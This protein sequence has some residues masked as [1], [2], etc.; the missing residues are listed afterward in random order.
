MSDSSGR[1]EEQDLILSELI[2]GV[3]LSR[4]PSGAGTKKI[5]SSDFQRAVADLG[6]PVGT[7]VVQDMLV[8]CK[9]DS[10]GNIDFAPLERE[11]VARRRILS[12]KPKPQAAPPPT[13][14]AANTE[15]IWRIEREHEKRVK[16]EQQAKLVKE[17]RPDLLT[18]FK[19]FSHGTDRSF[20]TEQVISELEKL[21]I[22]CTRAMRVLLDERKS[23]SDVSFVKFCAVMTQ[24]DPDEK[25][26]YDLDVGAGKPSVAS[27]GATMDERRCIRRGNFAAHARITSRSNHRKEGQ[28]AVLPNKASIVNDQLS[29]G[30]A[31]LYKD[32]S[33]MAAT[34]KPMQTGH[35][36]AM[37]TH[38]QEQMF[39][40]VKGNAPV[41]SYNSELRLQR[42]QILAALRKLDSHEISLDEFHSKTRAIGFEVPS[43]ILKL[44]HESTIVGRL[45]WR[46]CISVLDT[47]V[48][49]VKALDEVPSA[50]D[51]DAIKASI[52]AQLAEKGDGAS[53]L[54]LL[55]TAFSRMD[56][57]KNQVLS[58]NEFSAGVSAAGLDISDDDLRC[59]FHALDVN[60]DGALNISEF[61]ALLRP[62]LPNARK[63]YIRNAFS[64]LDRY[65]AQS[66]AIHDLVDGFHPEGHVDVKSGVKTARQV[67]TEMINAFRLSSPS[68]DSYDGLVSYEQFSNYLASLSAFIES[69]RDF[70]DMM[71]ACWGVT[72]RAPAPPVGCYAGKDLDTEGLSRP[73]AKQQ[74]GD[75]ISWNQEESEYEVSTR[76]KKRDLELLRSMHQKDSDVILWSKAGGGN[77]GAEG[78]FEGF[79]NRQ[80]SSSSRVGSA[81]T[82]KH[83]VKTSSVSSSSA[84]ALLPP[85]P[86]SSSPQ[87]SQAAAGFKTADRDKLRDSNN[88]RHTT[89]YSAAARRNFGGPTP[90]GVS[91]EVR[92]WSYPHVSRPSSRLSPSPPLLSLA[93]THT[94]PTHPQPPSAMY[95][96]EN[97]GARPGATSRGLGGG[98]VSAQ[99][100][101]AVSLRERA[102]APKSLADYVKQ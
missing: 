64:K 75:I 91:F 56:A 71:T 63:V 95:V 101:L 67:V 4:D 72:D 68:A 74:H 99:K 40:G 13:S 9:L 38:N 14:S 11:L 24:Y 21:G 81:M 18:I 2:L 27:D 83:G 3:L 77:Q 43:Y 33:S 55:Q 54:V 39:S 53:A 8:H 50:E 70:I 52:L 96:T 28:S 16:M 86:P 89:K 93:H 36:Q 61:V 84:S 37:L 58:F 73:A 6:F 94:P 90:F 46:K 42:E 45:D 88:V 87:D 80:S 34:L 102:N 30:D 47:T 35:S 1:D 7:P 32:S 15:S 25:P 85:P 41:I 69:D 29:Y 26:L 78:G 82:W 98:S 92:F 31:A 17:Y 59:V 20:G 51:V 49:K 66:V 76:K 65:R 60:G 12:A 97:A 44:L 23:T 5:H 48:F 19:R 10:S 62:P 22:M 57:D 79:R 100:S